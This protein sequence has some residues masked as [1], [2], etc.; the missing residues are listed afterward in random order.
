MAARLP[1]APLLNILVYLDIEDLYAVST[2]CKHWSSMMKIPNLWR[3]MCLKLD[4]SLPK[5]SQDYEQVVRNWAAQF[6]GLRAYY[7]RVRSVYRRLVSELRRINPVVLDGL[8]EPVGRGQ[9]DELCEKWKSEFQLDVPLLEVLP[10]E[11]SCWYL[12]TDAKAKATRPL[13]GVLD[14]YDIIMTA[15]PMSALNLG[16]SYMGGEE[17]SVLIAAPY[18]R[19]ALVDSPSF[20]RGNV[21]VSH[22]EWDGENTVPT[23][24]TGIIVADS[25]LNYI[26]NYVMMLENDVLSAHRR[27]GILKWPRKGIPEATTND[28]RVTAAHVHH[29]ATTTPNYLFLYYITLSM[30]ANV[31][32]RNRSKLLTR[33]WSISDLLGRRS[34]VNGP[35][36][37]GE[38]PEI[39]PG[40]SFSYASCC[41]LPTPGGTMEGYFTMQDL[42]TQERWQLVVPRMTFQTQRPITAQ[43]LSAAE[44]Q[45]S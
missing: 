20:K 28:L 17:H 19:L 5:E 38:F 43:T 4:L 26:E 14:C 44:F 9:F 37:I 42:V 11:V 12:M 15:H 13:F 3:E 10:P 35:G 31:T 7:P 33:H 39:G 23:P 27:F 30:D 45:T 36:V 8:T 1:H 40:D 34:D 32:G 18:M 6:A 25:W 2:I 24:S 22:A 29:P 41:P 21:W 16:S